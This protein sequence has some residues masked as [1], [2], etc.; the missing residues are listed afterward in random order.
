MVKISV[1]ADCLKNMSNA[2]KRGKRQVMIR[3]C[4]KVIVKFLQ[5]MQKHGTYLDL[6]SRSKLTLCC[7]MGGLPFTRI[8]F[9]FDAC[10][11]KMLNGL[12]ICRCIRREN[13]ATK[14]R[15]TQTDVVFQVCSQLIYG[16]LR[17]GYIGEFT[18]VDDHRSGKII[19]ELIGRIN[20]C[21]VISPRFD[22]GY[23]DIEQWVV[24]VRY[25]LIFTSFRFKC[26]QSFAIH[27]WSSYHNKLLFASP[28]VASFFITE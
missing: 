17:T 12:D 2:E 28:V 18:I 5:V 20:K 21:G 3:P 7:R 27:C 10:D 25:L 13:R 26:S 9:N 24:N 16:C 6:L 14:D 8:D 11:I 23:Y 1:L 15:H 19:I 22:V 4:S